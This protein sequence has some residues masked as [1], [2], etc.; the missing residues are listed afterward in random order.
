MA[1][2][3]DESLREDPDAHHVTVPVDEYRMAGDAFHERTIWAEVV[4][5]GRY[6]PLPMPMEGGLQTW[7]F[8]DSDTAFQFKMRFG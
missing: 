2:E 1:C 3:Y 6:L 8:S 7:A 5:Q 4:G